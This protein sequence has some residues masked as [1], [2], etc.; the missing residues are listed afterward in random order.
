MTILS[1]E[2]GVGKSIIVDALKFV[3]GSRSDNTMIRHGEDNCEIYVIFSIADNPTLCQWLADNDIDQNEDECH[4]RRLLKQDGKSRAYING[5]PATM[6]MLKTVGAMLIDIHSQ[7]EYHS[8]LKSENQRQLLD[9]Y[10]KNENLLDKIQHCYQQWKILQ[11]RLH[12]LSNTQQDPELLALLQF[13]IDELEELGL[14]EDEIIELEQ[15]QKRLRHSEDLHQTSLNVLDKIYDQAQDAVTTTLSQCINDLNTLQDIDERLSTPEQLLKQ[16]MIHTEEAAEELRLYVANLS[17][18]THEL[19]NIE[20]RLSKVFDIARKHRIKPE[21]LYTLQHQLYTRL[22]QLQ[23]MEEERLTLQDAI[24][25]QETAYLQV[26]SQLTKKRS[27]A[28]KK[29]GA[30]ATKLMRQLE[31][32]NSTLEVSLVPHEAGVISPYGQES[33][34]LLINTDPSQP[35]LAMNKI[36]SGGEL[37]RIS[38]ALQVV[39]MNSGE[40]LLRTMIF[41][42]VD[43]GIGGKVAEV[44]GKLL[45]DLGQA[46]Q[47]ICITHLPQVAA[48]GNHHLLI[49]KQ[50]ITG[51]D[52][53]TTQLQ[54]LDKKQRQE[55]IARMLGGIEISQ[56]AR[57]HAQ[58]MLF[59]T[60]P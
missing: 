58:E 50:K 59:N 11:D 51:Q 17:T 44:V 18:D 34:T 5:T 38:L 54:L 31:M 39:S 2:T 33:I 47:V 30:A 49:S 20:N 52:H 29:L 37:S 13:Q 48:Q 43:S 8:L 46:H 10:A 3:L 16:A 1:G 57:A 27:V 21:Q 32:R 35:L 45:Y 26:S 36:A 23:G 42:E 12:T 4:L 22:E 55:E 53:P 28:A 40:A 15:Q 41:D 7:H 60:N 9:S 24:D 19:D 56:A 6:Q 14:A 25:E